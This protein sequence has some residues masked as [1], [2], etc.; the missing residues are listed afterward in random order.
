MWLP[1][2]DESLSSLVQS[3]SISADN[4]EELLKEA[5]AKKWFP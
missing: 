3:T 1:A 4:L 2:A 5:G